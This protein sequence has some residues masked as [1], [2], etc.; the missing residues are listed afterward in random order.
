MLHDTNIEQ[1]IQIILEHFRN[2][3]MHELGG[4]AKAMVITG[5][6]QEAVKYKIAFDSYVK[7]K[8]Y[9]GIKAL[10]A[11]SG[12]VNYKGTEYRYH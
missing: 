7:R 8:G 9:S 5:S 11:F 10:V 12:K 6:R 2:S 4:E 3:V 1:R